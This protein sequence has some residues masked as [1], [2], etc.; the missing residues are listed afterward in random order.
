MC[1]KEPQLKLG[2]YGKNYH[3]KDGQLIKL[4]LMNLRTPFDM[5]VSTFHT[6]WKAHKEDCKDYTFEYLCGLLITNQHKL[7]E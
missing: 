5:F 6:N 2:E 4:V 3:K 7:L 1:V